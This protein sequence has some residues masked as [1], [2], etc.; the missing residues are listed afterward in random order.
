MLS[1]AR[2][3]KA[4]RRRILR[5]AKRPAAALHAFFTA[6]SRVLQRGCAI[7][8][9]DA[10]A[11]VGSPVRAARTPCTPASSRSGRAKGSCCA[12]GRAL[13]LSVREFELLVAMA[14]ANRARSSTREELYA[15]VW[16]G[17][18]RA[19]RPLGRRLREQAAGQARSGDARPQLHPHPS[20]LRLSLPAAAVAGRSAPGR[21][22]RLPGAARRR[23]IVSTRRDF[24]K[25]F[26]SAR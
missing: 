7:V 12:S 22:P 3:G 16:G 24:H 20:G 9:C 19:R 14:R 17:E 1:T 25:M 21:A 4:H 8:R 2:R 18:L 26:T 6:R 5:R 13:T 15:S 23:A 11:R 10:G